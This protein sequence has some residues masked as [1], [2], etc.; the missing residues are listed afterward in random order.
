MSIESKNQP[1]LFLIAPI[2]GAFA[3]IAALAACY[4]KINKL[5]NIQ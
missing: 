4:D 2:A 5:D 1:V 3:A